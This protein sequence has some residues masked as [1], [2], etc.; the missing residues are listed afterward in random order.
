MG[1]AIGIVVA[2]GGS[3]A[4]FPNALLAPGGAAAPTGHAFGWAFEVPPSVPHWYCP[5]VPF[6]PQ[7]GV[8][9]QSV[10]WGW[11]WTHWNSAS[12]WQHPTAG[13]PSHGSVAHSTGHASQKS[14]QQSPYD[15]HT[16]SQ[17]HA[18][19]WPPHTP[20][21]D[22]GERQAPASSQVAGGAQ[23]PHEPPQPS[24]PHCLPAHAGWHGTQAPSMQL[25]VSSQAPQEP[26]QPSGPHGRGEPSSFWQSGEQQVEAW[27]LWPSGQ[28]PQS[29]P[30]NGPH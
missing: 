13:T 16:G 19:D 7:N 29:R 2:A 20:Q 18:S 28:P 17:K 24:G 12:P 8:A 9:V 23:S 4:F 25:Y 30:Q 5:A 6:Q 22:P 11:P 15:W 27:Q 3:T 10:A 26:P 14:G 21:Q 1:C